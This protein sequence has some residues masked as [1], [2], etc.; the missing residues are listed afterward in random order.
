MKYLRL[1]DLYNNSEFNLYVWSMDG[2]I[3]HLA[4]IKD[5]ETEMYECQ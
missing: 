2:E 1:A 5:Y 4:E 3:C